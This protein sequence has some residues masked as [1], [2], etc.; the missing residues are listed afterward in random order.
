MNPSKKKQIILSLLFLI[1]GILSMGLYTSGKS[2]QGALY[3]RNIP[4]QIGEWEG[5]DIPMDEETM[6]LL[7]TRDILF[8]AYTKPGEEPVYLCVVF[9]QNNRRS[10][11]PPEVCYIASGWEVGDK[12]SIPSKEFKS[13]IDFNA[14]KILITRNY[15]KQLV[16]YWYKAGKEFTSSVA[17]HQLN[18]ALNQIMLKRIHG[19]LIRL[20]TIVKEEGLREAENRMN[21]F[22]S[23]AIP[24]IK[25]NLP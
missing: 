17:Q 8:R 11:H 3:A 19:A 13:N 12:K 23:K 20:S 14:T 4:L 6:R 5:I 9:A 22:A 16:Y 10:I 18:M 7:E 2:M 21:Q 1:T 25:D 24:L 15:D